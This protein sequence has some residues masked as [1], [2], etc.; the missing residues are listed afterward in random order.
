M[1]KIE[2]TDK[3]F[4]NTYDFLEDWVVFLFIIGGRGTG[5]TYS[6]LCNLLNDGE[7]FVF[8][9]R[10]KVDIENLCELDELDN[11]DLSRSPFRQINIDHGTNIKAMKTTG[12]T[13]YF[14]SMD[15]WNDR[16]GELIGS[17]V[18]LSLA[19]KIKGAGFSKVKKIFYDEF[20]PLP[21]ERGTK[22]DGFNLLTI[23]ETVNRNREMNGEEPVRLICCANAH[24]VANSVFLEFGLINEVSRAAMEG[25]M[26]CD[27]PD[28]GVRV[29][30]LPDTTKFT[31][32]KKRTAL[33]KAI[34]KTSRMYRSSIS[35]DFIGDDFGDVKRL[36][37]KHWVALYEIDHTSTSYYICAKNGAY[38]F[39]TQNPGKH[40]AQHFDLNSTKDRKNIAPELMHAGVWADF[41]D[42]HYTFESYEAKV[43]FFNILEKK[44]E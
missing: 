2:L 40:N 7:Q 27:L 23:Y 43:L 17:L 15:N 39:T 16:E 35:N 5:K 3:R 38:Y 20:I 32:E 31:E 42:G 22:D 8:V 21:S 9:R 44:L 11:P 33:Y 4:V 14:A 28:R 37:I 41:L 18:P 19:P 10:N 34:P 13:Y 30:L 36:S 6:T 29:V 26:L 25:R 12:E 1:K 24:T